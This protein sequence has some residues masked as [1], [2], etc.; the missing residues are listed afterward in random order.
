MLGWRA[1]AVRIAWTGWTWRRPCLSYGGQIHKFL[2]FL[3]VS[4]LFIAGPGCC[5]RGPCRR[6]TRPPGVGARKDFLG[7]CMLSHFQLS[8]LQTQLSRCP[9]MRLAAAMAVSSSSIIIALWLLKEGGVDRLFDV[10]YQR[11]AKNSLLVLS[12]LVQLLLLWRHAGAAAG[13]CAK[14]CTVGCGAA[15]PKFPGM[16]GTLLRLKTKT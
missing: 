14:I 8:Q 5:W 3:F 2:S 15:V 4:V 9:K 1:Q 13:R 7:H 11:A 6:N 12:Q 10:D 16:V